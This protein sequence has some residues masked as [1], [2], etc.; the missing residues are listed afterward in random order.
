M[1]LQP[2]LF[3]WSSFVL[4]GAPSPPGPL[5]QYWERGEANPPPLAPQLN[6][7]RP[8]CCHLYAREVM[9]AACPNVTVRMYVCLAGRINA[10]GAS[11]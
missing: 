6:Y 2:L 5:S 8:S 1:L 10:R 7:D 3:P 11:I 9:P 4:R